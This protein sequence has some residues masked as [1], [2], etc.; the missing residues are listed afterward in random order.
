MH[1]K[2]TSSAA[3]SYFK[4][5]PS[6]HTISQA[7]GAVSCQPA[8]S[9]EKGVLWIPSSLAW[10]VMTVS[11]MVAVRF[12]ICLDV[13]SAEKMRWCHCHSSA[14]PWVQEQ[15]SGTPISQI[16]LPSSKVLGS[17][18]CYSWSMRQLTA[19][20]LPAALSTAEGPS[21]GGPDTI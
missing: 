14:F 9:E 11:S 1:S 16:L 17:R 7:L 21:R 15:H 2:P 13:Q 19:S 18:P 8:C 3:A 12:S 5:L 4:A 20:P 6:R 10:K